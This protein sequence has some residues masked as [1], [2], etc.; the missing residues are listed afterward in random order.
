MLLSPIERSKIETLKVLD[1][2]LPDFHCCN[3]GQKGIFKGGVCKFDP[4]VS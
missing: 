4:K 1:I 3:V 2:V